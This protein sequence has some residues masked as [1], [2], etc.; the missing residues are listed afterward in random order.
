MTE[1]EAF[2]TDDTPLDGDAR[3]DAMRGFL[4]SFQDRLCASL[5]DEDGE[6]SFAGGSHSGPNGSLARPRV[7]ESGAVFD[8]AAVQFSHTRKGQLPPAATD[9]NPQLAGRAYEAVSVSVIAHPKNPFV[10]TTHCNL[11]YFH[12]EGGVWWFGGGFDLTPYYGFEEDAIAWHRAARDA[13]AVLGAGEDAYRRFKDACDRYFFLPHRQEARGIGGIFFDDLKAPGFDR[14]RRF[15]ERVAAAFHDTYL[16]IVR[17]RR[18]Q[19]YGD[20][21]RA[22]QRYRR[23]RY[24]EFNLLYDRGTRF[25][26]ES[27]GAVESILASLPPEVCWRHDFT[28][29]RGSAEEALVRD[30]LPARDWLAAR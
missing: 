11:R 26:L 9:R 16:A 29:E 5:A 19:P 4:L 3:I 22:F 17:R 21:E 24:V 6:A 12:V 1:N 8:R 7:L 18:D 2:L 28:A 13:C 14:C 25:G 30:Y 20:R 27:G 23:G 15:V 10:P